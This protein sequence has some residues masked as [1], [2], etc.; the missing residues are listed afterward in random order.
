MPALT[1]NV[2]RTLFVAFAFAAQVLLVVNFAARNWRPVL[3][4]RYGWVVYALG[5]PAALLA[6]ILTVAHQPAYAALACVL[7][8][9]WAAFGYYVDTY[10]QLAWRQPTRWTI[11]LPYVLLFIASQLAFWIPLWYVGLG[12]WVA[13]GAL[14]VANTALNLFS[15]RR[16]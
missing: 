8:A 3:E 5:I 11:L 6:A 4:R 13:Y 15:H 12:Y 16:A 1:H 14:Y 10:R 7:Y 9:L 2:L